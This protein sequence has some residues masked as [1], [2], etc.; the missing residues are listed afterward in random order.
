[1]PPVLVATVAF[2]AAMASSRDVPSPS[3]IR[4]HDEDVERAQEPEHVRAK[5]RQKHVLL[6]MEFLDLP[7][8]RRP[9]VAFAQDYEP[10]VRHFAHHERCRVDQ[11]AMAF[12][13]RQ[14]ARCPT[15]GAPTG[16]H[17]SA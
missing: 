2:E 1:M 10:R 4:R 14:C 11:M 3:E 8:E 6:E 12:F 5:P 15:M 7:L 16:N 17:S 13:H 9:V